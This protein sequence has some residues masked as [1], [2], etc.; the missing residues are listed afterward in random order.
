MFESERL[1]ESQEIG[2]DEFLLFTDYFLIDV[3]LRSLKTSKRRLLHT[4]L[5][6]HYN[7]PC[8]QLLQILHQLLLNF[9]FIQR[10]I[11]IGIVV[12]E[13]TIHFHDVPHLS[14]SV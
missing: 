9:K 7:S 10:V 11:Q 4:I 13:Y 1:S 5:I 12:S 3:I 14:I 6:V 8:D 2:F